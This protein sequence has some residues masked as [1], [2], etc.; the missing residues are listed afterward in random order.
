[1]AWLFLHRSWLEHR[2]L[3]RFALCTLLVNFLY[4]LIFNQGFLNSFLRLIGTSGAARSHLSGSGFL[5]GLNFI[6]LFI[7]LHLSLRLFLKG[8]LRTLS[9]LNLLLVDLVLVPLVGP[10]LLLQLDHGLLID[11]VLPLLIIFLEILLPL[12]HHV[13]EVR[14]R[15][16][17]GRGICVEV[18]VVALVP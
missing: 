4:H 7:L 16:V 15:S 11:Q 12:L 6:L 13:H 10:P 1:M 17:V 9:F 5:L 14:V 18:E 3:T 2:C 8:T